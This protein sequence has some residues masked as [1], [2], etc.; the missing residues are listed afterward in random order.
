MEGV[1]IM[2]ALSYSIPLRE[3]D[4]FREWL[5]CSLKELGLDVRKE[6]SKQNT[7]DVLHPKIKQQFGAIQYGGQEAKVSSLQAVAYIEL[8][9]YRK[10]LL[11]LH[12]HDK[13]NAIK[14]YRDD[15]NESIRFRFFTTDPRGLNNLLTQLRFV[16]KSL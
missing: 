5:S 13:L 8:R 11:T 6:A 16:F 2:K 3:A 9:F 7:W 15:C 12:L 4:L 10:H 1:F 14:D